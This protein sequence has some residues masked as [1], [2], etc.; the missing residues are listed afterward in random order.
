M[1]STLPRDIL[2]QIALELDVFSIA[3]QSKTSKL[4]ATLGRNQTLWNKLCET[5][6]WKDIFVSKL[7]KLK[8]SQSSNDFWRTKCQ[9]VFPNLDLTKMYKKQ[10]LEQQELNLKKSITKFN[11]D[12][13][14]FIGKVEEHPLK[15]KKIKWTSKMADYLIENTKIF[16]MPIMT[17]FRNAVKLKFKEIVETEP[18]T[19]FLLE[20]YQILFGG[21]LI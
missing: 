20:H 7:D 16:N 18:G 3:N 21:P 6:D 8:K 15:V 19:E 11:T 4:F 2:V 12:I 17:N 10:F 9:T 14:K 5:L 1:Y 13:L